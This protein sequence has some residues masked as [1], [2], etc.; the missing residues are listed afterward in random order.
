MAVLLGI[1][2]F[3]NLLAWRLCDMKTTFSG[4]C[5][6]CNTHSDDLVVHKDFEEG[7]AG[8]EYDVCGNCIKQE[9]ARVDA[10]LAED[11]YYDYDHEDPD[12]FFD[13]LYDEE[14]WEYS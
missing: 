12:P 11:G 13:Y 8:R 7:A 14:D 6:W 5:E 1:F 3:F 10:E 4:N 9:A 2:L